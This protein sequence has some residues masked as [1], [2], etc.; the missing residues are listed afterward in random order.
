MLFPVVIQGTTQLRIPAHFRRYVMKPLGASP[1]RPHNKKHCGGWII[2]GGDR[3][4][5]ALPR[6]IIL[7]APTGHDPS[8]LALPRP[9]IYKLGPVPI[10]SL[11]FP[12]RRPQPF[13]LPVFHVGTCIFFG[14][15]YPIAYTE[16]G[17]AKTE[18]LNEQLPTW[19]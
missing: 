19:T 15:E 5:L 16:H 1:P 9:I 12:H 18:E 17:Q 13:C 2:L 6:P 4:S 14:Y 10:L 11:S 7:G 8:S 3:S